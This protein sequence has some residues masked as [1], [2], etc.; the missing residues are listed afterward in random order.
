MTVIGERQSREARFAGGGGVP[1][2]A[3]G[4]E[5]GLRRRGTVTAA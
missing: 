2:R 5:S 1:S 3:G 4:S